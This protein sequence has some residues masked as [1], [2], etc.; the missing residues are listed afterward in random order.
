MKKYKKL[1]IALCLVVC[2]SVL[3]GSSVFAINNYTRCPHCTY[4][5]TNTSKTENV[6]DMVVTACTHGYA[7]QKDVI[8]PTKVTV[9]TQ[10]NRCAF[11]D[12]QSYSSSYLV[13]HLLY[14]D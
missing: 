9:T 11:Y 10:C 2:V 4:T 13:G 7:H 5:V 8:Q 14:T 1:S 3:F 6:G 12:S